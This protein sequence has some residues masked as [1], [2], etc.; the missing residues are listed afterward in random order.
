M[1]NQSLRERFSIEPKNYSIASRLI[2]EALIAGAIKEAD[3]DSKSK[4]YARYL[5]YWA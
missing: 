2:K 4:K 5:P 1:S 3:S